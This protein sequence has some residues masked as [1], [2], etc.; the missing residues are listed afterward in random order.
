MV[1]PSMW[2]GGALRT[3][4]L[5]GIWVLKWENW[6]LTFSDLSFMLKTELMK[7]HTYNKAHGKVSPPEHCTRSIDTDQF[8]IHSTS[9]NC[10]GV[11]PP[12]MSVHYIHGTGITMVVKLL[13]GCSKSKLGPSLSSPL[14]V[15][16]CKPIFQLALL[17]HYSAINQTFP[18]KEFTLHNQVLME[19][20]DLNCDSYNS[21]ELRV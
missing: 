18:I 11:L 10:M 13:F 21:T 15:I 6:T 9:F 1:M 16:F 2:V 5:G 3:S 20:K 4:L 19:I 14:H 12:Y 7:A 8:R 17:Y